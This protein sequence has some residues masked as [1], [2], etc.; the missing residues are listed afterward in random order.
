MDNELGRAAFEAY[1]KH[2]RGIAADGSKIPDWK[3]IPEDMKNS[4]QKGAEAVITAHGNLGYSDSGSPNVF[5]RYPD[6]IN[7]VPNASIDHTF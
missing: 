6:A 1:T 4:W 3:D 7:T 5:D 2:R